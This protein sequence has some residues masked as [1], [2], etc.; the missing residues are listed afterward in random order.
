MPNFSMYSINTSRGLQMK[1]YNSIKVKLLGFFFALSVS[2]LITMLVVLTALK[3]DALVSNA[4]KEVSLAT[5]KILSNLQNTKYRLEEI[6]LALASVSSDIKS[7]NQKQNTIKNILKANG[8]GVVTSGGI[9]FEPYAI[10]DNQKDFS[11]FFNKEYDDFTIVDDYISTN[12]INYRDTEFY[13]SASFLKKGET[14]WTKVYIDYVTKVRM[15]TVVSPIYSDDKF[16]GVASLDINIKEQGEKIFDDF[17]Y[18]NRYL[19]M[20]DREGSVVMKSTLLHGYLNS[21]RLY[22]DSCNE[23]L[24]EFK[25][26]EPIFEKCMTLDDYNNT[27]AKKLSNSL[28]ISPDES[29][30]IASILSHR[31]SSTK[32]G[33]QTTV[34]FIEDDPVFKEDSIVAIFDFPVTHWKLIIGIPEEQVLNESNSMYKQVIDASIYISLLAALIGYFLLR[35]LFINPIEEINDQLKHNREDEQN[36]Y[37]LLNSNDRGEIGALVDSLNR[38]TKALYES[39]G[40][41]AEEIQKRIVNEKLLEQQ[42]KMAAMGGMMDA[43]AHQ[44]KQPLNALSM[45]SDIIKSDFDDGD[46]DKGYISKFRDDI[47]LQIQHMVTTLDEFRIFFRPSRGDEHFNLLDIIRSV[48]FLTKDEFM[49]NSIVVNVL[50]DD[51]IELYGSKNEFK[52]LIL[53]IINNSKDAFNENKTE[54]RVIDIKIINNDGLCRVE[55]QD[56]AGGIPDKIINKIFQA[57]TTTKAEGKGTGIG[58]FM[59]MQIAEKF[60]AKL[61][62]VNKSGGACFIIVFS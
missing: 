30:R 53:N 54:K 49:K 12:P 46:V 39:E 14:Y 61:S 62:V 20:I 59:S 35:S 21:Q 9:W 6:S 32:L 13:M 58:L 8:S 3:N 1:W 27:M 52:H 42:S 15:L 41:E 51:E 2:F 31:E 24:N 16:I 55:I 29:K 57:H 25:D 48:L 34:N 45:Y 23:F 56:N 50:Q 26:M 17:K 47:Q 33:M 28:E 10:D 38:R 44:W 19:L 40:R 22:E 60:K 37:R 11:L 43:V 36:H 18:P 4:S 5:I 7:A